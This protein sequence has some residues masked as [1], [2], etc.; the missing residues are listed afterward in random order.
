MYHKRILQEYKQLAKQ[1]QSD[2]RIY[3]LNESDLT[4]WEA[5]IKGPP[6]TPYE[7]GVFKLSI[8]ISLNYPLDPPKVKFLTPIFHPNIDFEVQCL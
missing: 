3:P 8:N 5:L 1:T 6:D 7:G 2:L 4:E